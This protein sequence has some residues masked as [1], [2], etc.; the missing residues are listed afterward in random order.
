MSVTVVAPA[1]VLA[2]YAGLVSLGVRSDGP[3]TANVADVLR[4]LP[5]GVDYTYIK[6]IF[7]DLPSAI[8]TLLWQDA[9]GDTLLMAFQGKTIRAVEQHLRRRERLLSRM[10]ADIAAQERDRVVMVRHALV[11][12]AL[13]E[14]NRCT[15]S[16]PRQSIE[17][18]SVDPARFREGYRPSG[19]PDG[20]HVR[21]TVHRHG[22]PTETPQVSIVVAEHFIAAKTAP[23]GDDR[24]PWYDTDEIDRVIMTLLY[25]HFPEILSVRC[26]ARWRSKYSPMGWPLITRHVVPK[27]FELLKP[28]YPVRRYRAHRQVGPAGH[29]SARL[30][31]DIVDIIR[32]EFPHLRGEIT[33]ERVTAAIQRHVAAQPGDSGGSSAKRPKQ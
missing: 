22:D 31:R 33:L 4:R 14:V 1:V 30:R 23:W 2:C 9:S 25:R 26:G 32:L 16:G 3:A 28:F 6:A 5:E 15:G 24:I 10:D 18:V 27:L 12:V 7:I 17:I 11:E 19:G 13:H 8:P 21:I 20:H 29:Y